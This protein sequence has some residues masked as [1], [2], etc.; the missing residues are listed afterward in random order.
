MDVNLISRIPYSFPRSGESV[1]T[2]AEFSTPVKQAGTPLAYGEKSQSEK[3]REEV[4]MNLEQVQ[5]FLY[6]LIGSKL[7]IEHGHKL[8]GSSVNTAV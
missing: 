1:E 3:I 6:M 7:R 8:P 5:N 2:A 4:M